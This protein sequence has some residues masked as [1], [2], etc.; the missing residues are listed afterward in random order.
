[1]YNHTIDKKE[2]KWKAGEKLQTLKL[3]ELPKYINE[4]YEKYK[5]WL[6]VS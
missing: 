2:N 3:E 6:D 4:N 1:M 5:P